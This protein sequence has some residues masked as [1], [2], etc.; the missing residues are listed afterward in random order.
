MKARRR[1][2]LTPKTSKFLNSL[3]QL[4]NHFSS[5]MQ[6]ANNR[7]DN[8]LKGITTNKIEICYAHNVLTTSNY[9]LQYSFNKILET[10]AS[11]NIH[12]SHL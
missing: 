8:L 10:L 2:A 9:H 3:E 4:G 7:T 11:Q 5:F 1:N 12:L 6:T